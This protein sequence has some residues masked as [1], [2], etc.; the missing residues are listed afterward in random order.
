MAAFLIWR[1]SINNSFLPGVSAASLFRCL[2]HDKLSHI[3]CRLGTLVINR[4][5]LVLFLENLRVGRVKSQRWVRLR[6]GDER[7]IGLCS[8][9]LGNQNTVD[10]MVAGGKLVPDWEEFLAMT[11]PYKS[12]D[13]YR[14]H[15]A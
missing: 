11:T 9:I 6:L 10:K 7:G 4:C 15:K 2:F 14:V 5:I 13:S 12:K 8:I 3:L 1:Q